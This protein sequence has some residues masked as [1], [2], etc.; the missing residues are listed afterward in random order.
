MD[1]SLEPLLCLLREQHVERTRQ[2]RILRRDLDSRL[3][4]IQ[5]L[6][7]RIEENT[8]PPNTPPREVGSQILTVGLPQLEN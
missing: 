4:I 6:L 8:R 5:R 7:S 1:H 2:L 3:V